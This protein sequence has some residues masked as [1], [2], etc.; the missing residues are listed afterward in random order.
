MTHRKDR[1]AETLKKHDLS[2]E[3]W[4]AERERWDKAIDDEIAAGKTALLKT[5]DAAYIGALERERGEI[6]LDEYA[7]LAVSSERGTKKQVLEA[8]DLPAESVMR[9]ERVYIAKIVNNASFGVRVR[10]AIAAARKV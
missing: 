1:Q 4:N 3:Q 7:R 9:L 8:L 6:K 10:A 5:Y 2:A